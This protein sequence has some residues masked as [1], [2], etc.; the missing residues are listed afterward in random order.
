MRTCAL[1]VVLLLA[2]I[3]AVEAQVASPS[4][5]YPATGKNVN[6]AGYNYIQQ[7]ATA[8][9]V[10]VRAGAIP[11]VNGTTENRNPVQ[12]FNLT[13]TFALLGV[14]IFDV[15]NSFT[16]TFQPY[17]TNL[18]PVPTGASVDAAIMG[19]G[20]T[21]LCTV[22]PSRRDPF[23]QIVKFQTAWLQRNGISARRIQLGYDYGVMIANLMLANR[24]NDGYNI[25]PPYIPGSAPGQW[26]PTPPDFPTPAGVGWGNVT[27]WV[28]RNATAFVPPGPNFNLN[29]TAYTIDYYE[30]VKKGALIR[31]ASVT[32]AS[33]KRT[34]SET[35]F[36]VLWSN[37][38]DGSTYPPGLNWQISVNFGVSAGLSRLNYS[39]LLAVIGTTLADCGIVAWKTKYT[40]NDWRPRTGINLGAFDNI[41]ATT[42]YPKWQ[43][44]SVTSPAFPDYISGHSTF[45]GGWNVSMNTVVG[46]TH[47]FTILSD[48][49]PVVR[50]TYFR[51]ADAALDNGYSRVYLGV[52]W[53]QSCRDGIYTGNR[54]AQYLVQNAFLPL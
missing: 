1:A 24:S 16:P 35:Y 30:I 46:P 47:T 34:A 43:P 51:W 9:I 31:N 26:R 13:R 48:S 11:Q 20:Y 45:G 41:A 7:W 17:L 28:I 49:I 21:I 8:A 10:N 52:H 22:N 38:H 40:F 25:L 6:I 3:L 27:P 44:L 23:N 36:A 5:D 33:Q 32:V 12:L 4:I 39:R 42:G 18:P 15:V 53:R 29:T 54:V 2:V 14:S 37:D 50:T 19:A